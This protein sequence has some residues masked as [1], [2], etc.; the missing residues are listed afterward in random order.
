MLTCTLTAPDI[1]QLI[2]ELRITLQTLEAQ[3][4][5]QPFIPAAAPVT[6]QAHIIDPGPVVPAPII[7]VAAPQMAPPPVVPTTVPDYT[8]EALGHAVAAW[9]DK[10]PDNRNKALSLLQAQ[11]VQGVTQ[12]DTPAK[13]GAFAMALRALGVQ[14]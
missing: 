1:H 8:H 4:P 9:I 5:A 11:G 10:A 2:N 14:I 3:A 12:L 7:P 13:R 6:P